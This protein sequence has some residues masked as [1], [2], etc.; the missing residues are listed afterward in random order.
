MIGQQKIIDDILS[1]AKTTAAAMIEEATA[2]QEERLSEIR[3]ELEKKQAEGLAKAQAEADSVYTGM[4]KLGDLEANKALLRAK[5]QCLSAVYDGVKQKILAAP[6]AEYL[7]I[8]QTLIVKYASDGDEIIAAKRD[9]KRVTAAWVK[10]VGTAA[11]RKLA[12]SKET[13]DFEGGVVLRNG[14][15]DRD[16]TVDAIVEELKERTVS[17]VIAKLGL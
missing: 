11:K 14:K 15:F 5:Q 8:L 6:D 4:V 7:K 9:S 16:L 3:A 10:K 2:E 17:D 12:L 13:G 1:S